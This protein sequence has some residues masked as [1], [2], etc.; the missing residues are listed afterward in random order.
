MIYNKNNNRTKVQFDRVTGQ[1][2]YSGKPKMILVGTSPFKVSY[3]YPDG[4]KQILE[5]KSD[6]EYDEWAFIENN[7]L[8]IGQ[9][10]KID[11]D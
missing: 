4:S 2:I 1:N 9:E 5:I 6:L 3:T 11:W 10:I 7:K 8:Q